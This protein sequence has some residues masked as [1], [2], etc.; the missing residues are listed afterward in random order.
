[1]GIV[2]RFIR[3]LTEPQPSLWDI[4]AEH[5][6]VINESDQR[7]AESRAYIERHHPWL[8]ASTASSEA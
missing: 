6:R 3:A 2:R 5:E 8:T 7:V 4:R 1:M